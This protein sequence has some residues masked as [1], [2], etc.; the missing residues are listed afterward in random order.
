MKKFNLF[1]EIITA[2]KS[3]LLQAINSSKV[4]G[5]DNYGE[6]K[7]EPFT[8]NDIFIY[9]GK[10]TPKQASA[11]M[12]NSTPT[13]QT[14]LGKNYQVVEDDERVLIKA[15]SNWQEIIGFNTQRASYDDTTADG[16]AEF[17]NKNL[18]DI[19]WQ[20]TEFGITY[21]TLVE[22][23]EEK[24]EGT[25]IC[26]EQEDPYQFSGLGFIANNE[27]AK[28]ILFDYCQNKIKKLVNEEVEY[29]K[30]NITDDEKEAAEFFKVI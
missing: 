28:E 27:D 29:N 25:L 16:V 4:F 7:Y 17:S 8:D 15:F 26:I 6:V 2:N 5:I 14:I 9:I 11:L 12:Q 20:A 3:S 19:G 21:R 24:C 22:Y 13:L 23:L 1:K 10:H 30:D 18:E